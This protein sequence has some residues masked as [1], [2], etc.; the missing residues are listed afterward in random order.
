MKY[1]VI[2]GSLCVEK[3]EITYM[4]T[5]SVF[6]VGEL[7]QTALISAFDT[8]PEEVIVGVTLPFIGS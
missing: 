3:V 8:P 1:M 5:S 6:L 7:K 4:S 2:N